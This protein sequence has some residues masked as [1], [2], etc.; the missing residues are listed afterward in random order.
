MHQEV[1]NKSW[2]SR[3]M[4]SIKGVAFGLLIFLLAF[5]LLYW[6]EGRSAKA[7]K[8]IGEGR[9]QVV[10]IQ[11]DKVDDKYQDSLVHITGLAS[12]TE[13]LRDREFEVSR[14][15]ALRLERK[16]EMFQ[17]KENE[18]KEKRKKVGGGEETII[19][20]TYE[21]VWSESLIDSSKFK[22]SGYENPRFMKFK[23]Q[24]FDARDV[25]LGVFNLKPDLVSQINRWEPFRLDA[26]EGDD[27]F[28][29]NQMTLEKRKDDKKLHDGGYYF[30]E[31]PG[32]PEI[33]DLKVGFRVV[34]PTTVSI[35]A[36][37]DENSF[38]PFNT[39][40]GKKIYRLQVGEHS[41]TEMF[42]IL[43]KENTQT[44][45]IL[46]GIFFLMMV[47]GINMIFRP[48]VVVADV[49]PLFGN[50]LG[51]GVGIF[52]LLVATPLWLLTVA[53]GWVVHRP[54]VGGCLLALAVG[55]MVV[56]KKVADKR[57]AAG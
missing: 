11:P 9:G 20:Y 50:L 30:G 3:L 15:T 43:K 57:K 53:A 37:Q 41:A 48:L 38:K 29:R 1:V 7:S 22:E 34:M 40:N 45:W 47:L 17:W 35:V 42:D 18:S 39:S 8:A 32:Q 31:D 36:A 13:K 26:D 54:F 55:A 4:E 23:S 25:D 21:K 44:T 6:N 49:V 10:S 52:S 51:T 27:P 19:T 33:G 46:R 24:L 56:A 2:F 5:P 28:A 12:S 14:K 16:V